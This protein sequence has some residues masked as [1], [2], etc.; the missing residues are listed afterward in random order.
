MRARSGNN[1]R[2]IGS[3]AVNWSGVLSALRY[4]SSTSV[5]SRVPRSIGASSVAYERAIAT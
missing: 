5:V 1:L 2:A 3:T 4:P